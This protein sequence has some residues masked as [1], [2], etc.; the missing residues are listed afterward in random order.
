MYSTTLLY[1]LVRRFHWPEYSVKDVNRNYNLG[2][3]ISEAPVH[4]RVNAN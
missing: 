3:D 2:W 4:E 1:C